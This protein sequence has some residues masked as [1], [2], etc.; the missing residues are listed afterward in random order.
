MSTEKD[1]INKENTTSNDNISQ[2]NSIDIP[3]PKI[4]L[5]CKSYKKDQE[6]KINPKSGKISSFCNDC[7]EKQK[8]SAKQGFIKKKEEFKINS[9][10]D[11]INNLS[12]FLKKSFEDNPTDTISEVIEFCL[13]Q[14]IIK[15]I[16]KKSYEK[17]PNNTTIKIIGF[18]LE[19]NIANVTLSFGK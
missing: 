6:F 16:L 7:S 1:S 10:T 5:Y 12:K 11:K 15:N 14:D 3:K 8:E 17:S 9:K 4:C 13:E 18:C 19:N 2:E